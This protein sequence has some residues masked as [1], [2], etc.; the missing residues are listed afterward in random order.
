LEVFVEDIV[1]HW[2]HWLGGIV[3]GCLHTATAAR[4]IPKLDS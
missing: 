1:A 4:G 2:N 3:V